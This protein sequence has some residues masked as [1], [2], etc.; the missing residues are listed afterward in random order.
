MGQF[1]DTDFPTHLISDWDLEANVD[2]PPVSVA[3][4]PGGLIEQ[5]LLATNRGRYTASLAQQA[6]RWGELE[7]LWDFWLTVGQF[8]SFRW[9]DPDPYFNRVVKAVLG[10]GDG[11]TTAFQLVHWFGSYAHK[12]TKPRAGSIAVLI[13]SGNGDIPQSSRYAVGLTT[14]LV[15]FS[16]DLAGTV[17]GATAASPV[18]LTITGHGLTSG[19]TVHC[20]GFTG[21]WAALNANRYAVTV[22][23]AN[24]VSLPVDGS[25][26][27]AW[28]SGGATHTLPQAGEVPLGSCIHDYQVRLSGGM[29]GSRAS[30]GRVADMESFSLLEVEEE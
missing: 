24:T 14:G 13:R 17:S 21:D 8:Y 5:R 12:V 3:S 28:V 7:A 16:A 1:L 20:S 19:D 23:D 25:G 27:A 10:A 30:P 26:W 15:T 18:Q 2:P 4:T 11:V 22:I 9:L 29:R 6:R